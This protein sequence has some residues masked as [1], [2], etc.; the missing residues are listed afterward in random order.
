[1]LLKIFKDHDVKDGKMLKLDGDIDES[2]MMVLA[3]STPLDIWAVG[4]QNLNIGTAEYRGRVARFIK[5]QP[6][7]KQICISRSSEVIDPE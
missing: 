6:L 7:I 2:L 1:M 4:F 5:N 3:F